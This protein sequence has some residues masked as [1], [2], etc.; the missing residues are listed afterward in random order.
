[1][2]EAAEEID[3]LVEAGMVIVNLF[4]NDS[5]IGTGSGTQGRNTVDGVVTLVYRSGDALCMH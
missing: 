2:D 4:V 1:M 3:P 5:L